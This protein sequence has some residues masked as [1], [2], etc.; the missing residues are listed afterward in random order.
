MTA[1]Q[2]EEDDDGVGAGGRGGD[3]DED[4]EDESDIPAATTEDVEL[5]V[6]AARKAL[7][8]ESIWASSSGAYSA[9]FL[10]AIA[11]KVS[12]C[13]CWLLWNDNASV[14]EEVVAKEEPINST[15]D[16]YS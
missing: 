3:D 12:V 14:S 2:V 8:R 11:A 13:D 15:K 7:A 6:G 5:A 1:E 9:K 16:E 4:E 10:C